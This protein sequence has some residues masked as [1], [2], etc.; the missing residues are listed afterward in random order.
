M[1][2]SPI[3]FIMG[4]SGCGKSTIGKLLAQEFTLP[5]FDGD[6]YHPPENIDKMAA[7]KPLNDH[8]R[9]GWLA[10]INDLA[11]T[12]K[13]GAVIAC[14][15]LKKTYRSILIDQL[16]AAH[17]VYLKGTFEE[18]SQRLEARKNHF[19]PAGLLQSQFD[20]LEVPT[21]AISVSIVDSPSTIVA[22]ITAQYKSKKKP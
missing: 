10:R 7:G 17:F 9:A 15:A 20:I 13:S 12:Q 1:S 18:I 8:D 16:H 2:N 3:F 5:F 22:N 14:S 19:M 21:N 6:D 4:V 11:K